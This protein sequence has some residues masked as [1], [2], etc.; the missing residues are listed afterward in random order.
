MT[1]EGDAAAQ[2]YRQRH[3]AECAHSPMSFSVRC[4]ADIKTRE[5]QRALTE[6]LLRHRPR[7]LQRQPAQ[8]EARFIPCWPFP[9]LTIAYMSEKCLSKRTK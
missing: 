2:A 4:A 7:P 9:L 5:G 6:L 8:A 1:H 3:P